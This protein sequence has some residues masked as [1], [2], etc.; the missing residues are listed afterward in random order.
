MIKT[1]YHSN[2]EDNCWYHARN[3]VIEF[4][5]SLICDEGCSLVGES[6]ECTSEI[7]DK[8]RGRRWAASACRKSGEAAFS[9]KAAWR[10]GLVFLGKSHPFRHEKCHFRGACPR[11]WR[12]F[13]LFHRLRA[14]ELCEAPLYGRFSTA[15]EAADGRPL[16]AGNLLVPDSLKDVMNGVTA[17]VCHCLL[18]T[19]FKLALVLLRVYLDIWKWLVGSCSWIGN[20]VVGGGSLIKLDTMFSSFCLFPY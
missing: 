13:N 19:L 9:R 15:G 16:L 20:V 8:W 6:E 3:E 1:L 12:I 17:V 5:N 2:E 11:K 14:V 18:N 4:D 10:K 7:G